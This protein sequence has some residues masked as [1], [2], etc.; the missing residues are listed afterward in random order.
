MD[1]SFE[2]LYNF[3]DNSGITIPVT[4]DVKTSVENTFKRIF[5]ADLD[6]SD[7]TPVGR[8]IEAITLLFVNVL[9]VNAQNANGFNVNTAFGVYLDALA[10]IFGL[11]RED[12]ENDEAFRNRILGSQSRG[13]GYVESIRNAVSN[14]AGVT[15]VCVLEN[16]HGEPAVVP[17]QSAGITIPPHSVFVCVEGGTDSAVAEAIYASKS[18]GCGYTSTTEYG[19]PVTVA[20]EDK[21]TGSSTPVTFYRPQAKEIQI[22]VAVSNAN[23]SGTDIVS[24]VKTAVISFMSH[25]GVGSTTTPLEIASHIA[26]NCNGA[27]AIGI[28][29]TVD[30]VSSNEIAV[31]P[32]QTMSVTDEE[33]IVE[34]K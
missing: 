24:D 18:A 32:Y 6:V 7:E 8:L 29:I 3:V 22:S 11:S 28:D 21:G 5:G 23:Y 34:V 17:N 1:F 12:G 27:V 15:S 2:D 4:T 14:V 26:L 9:G 31:L 10:S 30:G 13:K 20:V 19:T 16:C 33:V 25:K